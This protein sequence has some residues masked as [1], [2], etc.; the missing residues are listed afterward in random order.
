MIGVFEAL[1]KVIKFGEPFLNK[2]FV[3]TTLYLDIEIDSVFLA[4]IDLEIRYS[5]L[6]R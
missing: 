2:P 4:F 5:N 1:N 6:D 3:V